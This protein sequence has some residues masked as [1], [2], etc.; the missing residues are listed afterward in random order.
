[1]EKIPWSQFKT[2]SLKIGNTMVK[3]EIDLKKNNIPSDT[4]NKTET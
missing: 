4:K 3:K 1:M 2:T